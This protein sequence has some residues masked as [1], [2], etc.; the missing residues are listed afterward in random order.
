[1][2]DV[3][4][5]SRV[6]RLVTLAGLAASVLLT[7]SF[8]TTVFAQVPSDRDIVIR[9]LKYY[10]HGD[11]TNAGPLFE[12]IL[13]HQPKDIATRKLMGNCTLNCRAAVSA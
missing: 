9:S 5:P 12:K 11:C 8:C 2:F 10:R 1:M 6:L 7:I 13:L 3:A 4:Q